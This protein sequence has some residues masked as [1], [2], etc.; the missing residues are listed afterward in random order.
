VDREAALAAAARFVDE[1][2]ALHAEAVAG[3]GEAG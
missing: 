3:R 2:L 1:A